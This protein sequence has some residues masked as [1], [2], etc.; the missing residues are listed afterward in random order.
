MTLAVAEWGVHPRRTEEL[1]VLSTTKGSHV[2]SS[3]GN[4]SIQFHQGSDPDRVTKSLILELS[5]LPS[6]ALDRTS[7]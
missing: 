1:K 6:A 3:S 5:A 7:I 2:A 4:K